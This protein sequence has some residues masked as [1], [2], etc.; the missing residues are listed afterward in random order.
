MLFTIRRDG[1]RRARL[2]RSAMGDAGKCNRQ[3]SREAQRVLQPFTTN[4]I[5]V[6]VTNANSVSRITEVDAFGW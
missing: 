3:Q 1:L 5:Q 4:K 2:G 6:N